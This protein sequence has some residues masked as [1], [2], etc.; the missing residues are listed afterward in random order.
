MYA[1]LELTGIVTPQKLK[2][3]G[4][5]DVLRS[6]HARE[7]DLY[8]LVV[9]A[10]V[11]N[12]DDAVNLLF[13]KGQ[14]ASAYP[15]L[16]TKL[17]ELLL[18]QLLTIDL[19]TPGNNNRQRAY[20]E[21]YK[22]WGQ[23]KLLMG[24]NAWANTTGMAEE[25]L[26]KARK[27]EFTD[28]VVDLARTLRLY[29]GSIAGVLKKYEEYSQLAA[30]WEDA[31]HFEN[32]AE[33]LYTDLVVRFVNNKAPQQD[34]HNHAQ[35]CFEQLRPALERHQTYRLHLSGRLI[36]NLIYTSINDYRKTIEVCEKAVNFFEAKYY[37]TKIPLQIFLYQ[38]MVCY[39]QLKDFDRGRLAADKGLSLLNEGSFN[40]FKYQE[41]LIF[42]S[43][44]TRQYQESYKIFKQTTGHRRFGALPRAIGE[45]WR[46]MEA[47][48]FYLVEL[49][50]I[51]PAEDD[52]VFSKFRMARFI[53]EMPLFSRDKRGMNIPILIFQILS[54]IYNKRYDAA[55]DRMEAIEKYCSRYLRRDDTFRSNCFIK[56]LLVI[57]AQGF[58]KS[59][60]LRH[61][62]KYH[63]MLLSMPI[64]MANQS[65]DVEIIPY[66]DL[67]EMALES[68][69]NKT[70]KK[71]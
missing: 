65:H 20:F 55:I 39:V 26:K 69:Q 61:A 11:R 43:L 56:M 59:A 18:S 25:T 2:A 53:N 35:A 71:K 17:Q 33:A 37:P 58:H 29:F 54:L 10:G 21:C 66:E 8:Q 24:R 14:D 49:G 38:E 45:T 41:L 68:L 36:E 30:V 48:L 1:I 13:P 16:K 50:K 5:W 15:E 23:I 31:F 67:W 19:N 57:P 40:W 62:E 70:H 51:I 7:M 6:R 27:F 32:L 64:D 4:V 28:I 46:I 3:A 34:V 44:H 9:N 22:K 12:D 52:T 63:K 60:V 47:Y 42:L